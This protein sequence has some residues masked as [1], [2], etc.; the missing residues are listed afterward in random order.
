MRRIF[1]VGLT[2]LLTSN[3]LDHGQA[4]TCITNGALAAVRAR[5]AAIA[6]YQAAC[7]QELATRLPR[8]NAS[9]HDAV[10]ASLFARGMAPYGQSRSMTLPELLKDMYLDCDNYAILTAYLYQYLPTPTRGRFQMVGF[11]GGAVG[12]HAQLIFKSGGREILLDP[13]VGIVAE[14]GFNALL[15]GKPIT[16]VHT[17][18]RHGDPAIEPFVRRVKQAITN[19]EYRPSDLLYWFPTVEGY[20]ARQQES[21]DLQDFLQGLATPGARR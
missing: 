1:L 2:L 5:P 20:I 21:G 8:L 17:F 10:I 4:L 12:N 18:Y 15:S 6:D 16:E 7:R 9:Q 14:I 13:T 19:G 11:N 3:V